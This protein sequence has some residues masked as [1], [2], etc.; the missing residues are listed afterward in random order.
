MHAA[1][2]VIQL[3]WSTFEELA[4]RVLWTLK[5]RSYK[6]PDVLRSTIQ[7]LPHDSISLKSWCARVSLIFF[8]FC[9]N[10][11]VNYDNYWHRNQFIMCCKCNWW[12]TRIGLGKFLEYFFVYRIEYRKTAGIPSFSS[13]TSRIQVNGDHRRFSTF[14]ASFVIHARVFNCGLHRCLINGVEE[15]MWEPSN[16]K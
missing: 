4:G 13:E 10:R 9:L 15:R 12:E 11:R 5:L 7:G 1:K 3:W 16:T 2:V 6:R 14:C 8:V